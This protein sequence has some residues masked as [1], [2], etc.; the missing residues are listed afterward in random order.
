MDRLIATLFLDRN[1]S[2]SNQY[3]GFSPP[4]CARAGFGLFSL[5]RTVVITDNEPA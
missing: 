4:G 2:Q 3:G 1:A 5:G